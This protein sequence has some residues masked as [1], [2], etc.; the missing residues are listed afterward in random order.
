MT[1]ICFWFFYWQLLL[2]HFCIMPELI[3]FKS[4]HAFFDL[5]REARVCITVETKDAVSYLAP[6]RGKK[7]VTLQTLLS[8]PCVYI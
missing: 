1:F 2:Y 4:V 7:I 3:V 6:T 5:L 8:L